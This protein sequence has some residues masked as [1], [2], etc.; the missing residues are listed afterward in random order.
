MKWNEFFSVNI[1]HDIDICFIALVYMNYL[2][3]L[4]RLKHGGLWHDLFL[5]EQRHHLLFWHLRL[6][7]DNMVL[8]LR[9]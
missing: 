8:R 3:F 7:R 5:P 9:K 1:L 4:Q 6:R 2:V